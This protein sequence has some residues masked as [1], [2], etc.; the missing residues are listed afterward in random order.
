MRGSSLSRRQHRNVPTGHPDRIRGFQ[1]AA[2]HCSRHLCC[3]SA[4][5]KVKAHTHRPQAPLTR[6]CQ[7]LGA[8][9]SL[10]AALCGTALWSIARKRFNNEG[11]PASFGDALWIVWGG[12][13]ASMLA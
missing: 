1:P 4:V 13:A 7:F 2:Q 3:V 6:A 12:T 11:A 8:L 10:V 5:S 9:V